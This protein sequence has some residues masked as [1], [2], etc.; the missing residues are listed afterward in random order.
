MVGHRNFQFIFCFNDVNMLKGIQLSHSS[1]LI[2]F[3]GPKFGKI[4]CIKKGR[5]GWNPHFTMP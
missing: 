1:G 5:A 4:E 3:Y 2:Y